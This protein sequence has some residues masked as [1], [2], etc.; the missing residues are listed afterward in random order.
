[1]MEN[2]YGPAQASVTRDATM[3]TLRHL[4]TGLG[5]AAVAFSVMSPEEVTAAAD[6]IVGIVG[7]VSFLIGLAASLR[8]KWARR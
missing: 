8:D 6:A 4:L 7:A 3:G 5:G 2:P 1:M